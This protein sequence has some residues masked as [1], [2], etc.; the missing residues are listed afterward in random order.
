MAQLNHKS[1]IRKIV[2][3][4]QNENINLLKQAINISGGH[5]IKE[6][7][8][9]RGFLCEFPSENTVQIAV[10][11][12]PDKVVIEEDIQFKLCWLPYFGFPF[13]SYQPVTKPQPTMPKKGP[14]KTARK[15]DWGLKRIG[16]PLVWDK[17]KEKKVRVGII[18]TGIDYRH[19][20]LQGNVR[21]GVSTLDG[22]SSF[23]DDYGHGTH[24]A[25]TIGANNRYGLIGINPYVEFYAVKAFD[26]EGGGKL[27]DIIEGIDWLM[28]RQVNI[29]N[30]SFS[31]N[32]TSMAFDRA[33][34][35]AYSQGVVLVAA[36]GNDGGQNS[37]N[38]PARLPEVIAVS[39]IDSQDKIASFSS[40][41]PQVD[42]CAPGVNITSAWL[43]GGYESKSGTS[44]AAPHITGTVADIINFFGP[45]SPQEIRRMLAR[46]AVSIQ[47][48]SKSEQGMGI[49]EIPR[50]IQ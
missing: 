21:E 28:R 50:I 15:I 20:D 47:G 25:A 7:P 3:F 37:V 6:L 17:L 23:V 48:L 2:F 30:M 4:Q 46:G 44:F 36:A 22:H 16:A 42:F 13:G 38:Y 9:I 45:L 1:G 34:R 27:A 32:E 26:K 8:L 5:V 10:R 41:G 14:I 29:I 11:N 33:I 49:I 12:L 39:A 19:P 24:I 40:N 18:D 43:R 31:T 35:S